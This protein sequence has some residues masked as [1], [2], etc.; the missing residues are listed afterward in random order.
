[1]KTRRVTG[2]PRVA[3]DTIELAEL[4]A[5][6]ASALLNAKVRLDQEA[7]AIAERYKADPLLSAFAPPVFSIG[8][9][10]VALKIAIASVEAP[11]P[12]QVD[13]KHSRVRVHVTADALARIPPH[14]IS[15]IEFRIGPEVRGVQSVVPSDE[16]PP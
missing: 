2:Q 10:R 5:A 3:V 8:D 9:A 6:V 16:N 1:M 15:E 12:E 13:V 11:T 14:L 4:A 7:I